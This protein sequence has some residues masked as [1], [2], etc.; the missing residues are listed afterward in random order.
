VT[1]Y[2]DLLPTNCKQPQPTSSP[3]QQ[4][5]SLHYITMKYLDHGQQVGLVT[6]V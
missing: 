2:L 6:T 3:P 5:I 4:T 1:K